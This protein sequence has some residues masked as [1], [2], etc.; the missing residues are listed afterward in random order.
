MR[1]IVQPAHSAKSRLQAEVKIVDANAAGYVMFERDVVR[2]PH[3]A[4]QARLNI[5]RERGSAGSLVVHWVLQGGSAVAG[6]HRS[7]G[8]GRWKA[9]AREN[10]CSHSHRAQCTNTF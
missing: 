1:G 8:I 9:A 2:V 4:A 10:K 3:T 6:A 5:V 7:L